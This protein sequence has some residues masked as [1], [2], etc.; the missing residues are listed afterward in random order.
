[1][2]PLVY[3]TRWFMDA[4]RDKT[5]PPRITLWNSFDNPQDNLAY[6]Q[7][8]SNARVVVAS[9]EMLG[10]TCADLF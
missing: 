8:F 3:G 5:M 10:L 6:A 7:R 4:S 1:V 9:P 2:T